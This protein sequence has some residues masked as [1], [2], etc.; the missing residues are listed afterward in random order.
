LRIGKH[1]DIIARERLPS[2][3]KLFTALKTPL[4]NPLI[5]CSNENVIENS[6]FCYQKFISV[7]YGDGMDF[8]E[9]IACKYGEY[10]SIGHIICPALNNEKIYFTRAGFTH[11]IRKE[12]TPREKSEQI[13]RL[14]L[15]AFVPG[16]IKRANRYITY[17]KDTNKKDI[18]MQTWSLQEKVNGVDI[19]V[20]I[21]QI[22]NHPKH[23]FSVFRN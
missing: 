18:R 11:L 14:T 8:K 23:F 17:F 21:R 22:D 12:K 7:C 3:G 1:E 5:L 9:F 13:K 20:I 4:Q 19:T 6:F 2:E 15:L 10:K 16:I